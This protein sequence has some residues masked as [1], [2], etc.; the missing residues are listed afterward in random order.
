MYGE[1][2]NNEMDDLFID[3]IVDSNKPYLRIGHR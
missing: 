1:N 3:I 2:S